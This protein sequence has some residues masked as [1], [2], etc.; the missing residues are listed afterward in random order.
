MTLVARRLAIVA[1]IALGLAISSPGLAQAAVSIPEPG[2][3]TLL[4]LAAA[5]LIVGRQVARRRRDD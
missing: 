2:D 4:A 1:S 5:G 3:M